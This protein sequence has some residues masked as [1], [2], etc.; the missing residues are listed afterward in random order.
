MKKTLAL[1]L[2]LVMVAF[3]FA[4][5]GKKA[6][7]ATT[8]NQATAPA[9]TA[10]GDSTKASETTG[11]A[12]QPEATEPEATE[13]EVTEPPH[14]HTPDAEWTVIDEPT[15]SKPGKKV[16][17]CEEC[18]DEIDEEEIPVDPDAHNVEN[19]VGVEPTLLLQSGY[20]DGTCTICNQPIHEDLVWAP[21]VFNSQS[22]NG[23]YYSN[24]T[25]MVTK[26]AAEARGDDKHYYPTEED[27]DGNDLWFEYTFLWNPSFANW[28]GLAEMEVAGL[29]NAEANEYAKHR[30]LYYCMMRNDVVDYCPYAGHFDYTTQFPGVGVDCF[31]DP[32]NG[33][34]IYPA[35][36]VS[37]VTEESSPSFGEYGWHR[38]GV[39]YHQEIEEYDEAKGG[40]VYAGYHELYLDGV[41]IW[42]TKTNMQG[43]WSSSK[44][45]WNTITTPRTTFWSGSVWTRASFP[46]LIPC[47]SLSTTRS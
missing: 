42:V 33:Q 44:Q 4:S 21:K 37:P 25:F 31:L 27:F 38:V 19:W 28:I 5:C 16:L 36:F 2:M 13:P 6:A 35:D 18:D 26:S 41:K 10:S 46:P 7:D 17:Y 9:T 32:G 3:A 47:S 20:R 40:V 22:P 43:K 15:C 39:H 34:P 11:T 24:G 23:E 14:E 29:W 30:P 45:S 1:I 8:A 12:T